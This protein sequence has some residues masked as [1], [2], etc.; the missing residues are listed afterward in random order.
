MLVTTAHSAL[1]SA[2]VLMIQPVT[3]AQESAQTRNVLQ[4]LKFTV[5]KSIVKVRLDK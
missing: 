2:T 3:R 4:D 1:T 5:D